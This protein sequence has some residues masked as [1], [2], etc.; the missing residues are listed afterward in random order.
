[1]L[2]DIIIKNWELDILWNAQIVDTPELN[3]FPAWTIMLPDEYGVAIPYEGEESINE[4][5]AGARIYSNDS[6]LLEGGERKRV[7]MLMTA[8]RDIQIPF[9]TLC[10]GLIAPGENGEKREK[11]SSSPISW[12]KEWKELLGNKNVDARIY[13]TL[14]ELCVLHKLIL[15]GQDAAWNGP[16]GASYDIETDKGFFEAKS[17]LYRDRKE[18]TISSQFQLNPPGKPLSLVLCVFERSV[19]SGISIDSVIDDIAAIGY[20]QAVINGKLEKLGFE[21]G[22]SARRKRFILHEMLKYSIDESFPRITPSSF[23]EGSLPT[24]ITKI[25]YTV[26]LNGLCPESIL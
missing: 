24:G 7:L 8:S 18:V 21:P 11:I 23:K 2:S 14:G 26:D 17:T 19:D 5:F 9:S 20:N 15:A 4:S 6:L 13:D 16:D 22:M 3:G 25:T 1:M 10:A 12:W